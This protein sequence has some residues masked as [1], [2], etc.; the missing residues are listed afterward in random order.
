M[1]V[2]TADI[3]I[4]PFKPVKPH[5]AKWN[6]SV[7]KYTDSGSFKIPAISRLKSTG[8]V[9]EK[10]QTG[11]QFQEG[12]KVEIHTGY[13]GNNYL[14]FKGF[15]SRINFTVPLEV[16]CEGYSY[17]LRKKL[18]FTKAYKNTTAKKILLDLI[19]GTDI[20]LSDQIPDIPIE[21]A[22]FE[23]C[24]G[25]EVLEWIKEKCLLT[26][27]FNFDVLYVGLMQ[28]EPKATANFRLGW[29]TVKDSDLK[30][31]N[32]KEFADVRIEL[33]GRKKDGTRQKAFIGKKTGQIK[34]LKTAIKDQSA[35]NE[36]IKQKQIEIV[37]KGYE[38]SITGFLIP[39]V[40][41]GMAIHIE[42]TKYPERT[43]KYFCTGV[44]GDFS[45]SGGRQ[46]I[47][48]GNSLG[49]G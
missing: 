43:G 4:G 22:T 6:C 13:G 15:I 23:G 45:P 17:Q 35:L 14:R 40:M 48:I 41:P 38:G 10:V 18:N 9:Y 31:N 24:T 20:V 49:N 27:Y 42:D 11:L 2:M 47:Q 33:S 21:K 26:V 12:M 3:F 28:L 5:S 34:R 46:K 32:N 1:F 37:N 7:T 16:E 44:D 30:F 19:Q 29:N 39:Y 8:G 36:I 25:V